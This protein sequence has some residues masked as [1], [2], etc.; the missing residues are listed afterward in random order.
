MILITMPELFQFDDETGLPVA[1]A[2]DIDP[3]TQPPRRILSSDTTLKLTPKQLFAA[4]SSLILL[5]VGAVAAYYDLRE[6]N[7]NLRRSVEKLELTLTVFHSEMRELEQ[8]L[9][10]KIDSGDARSIE[11][12]QRM[13]DWLNDPRRFP[14]I[15]DDVHKPDQAVESFVP[16][17][18]TPKS[19]GAQD[20]KSPEVLRTD[21][22]AT[23]GEHKAESPR[24]RRTQE[25][26]RTTSKAPKET[27][28]IQ[29]P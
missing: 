17:T 13:Q 16:Q 10:G 4:C 3:P 23:L 11:K 2:S 6:S 8:R 21:R 20:G 12:V 25:L 19:P 28:S 14:G 15:L 24:L 18:Q 26:M 29:V 5:I 22:A 1:G 27:L 9:N 7:A